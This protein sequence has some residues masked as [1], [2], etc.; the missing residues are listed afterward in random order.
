MFNVQ[1][2]SALD[3]FLQVN[4]TLLTAGISTSLLFLTSPSLATPLGNGQYTFDRAPRFME[5]NVSSP[6][7]DVPDTLYQ[8][9]ITV[10][11]DAGAPLQAIRI[12]QPKNQNVVRFQ[13]NTARVFAENPAAEIPLARIGGDQPENS[14]LTVEFQYP[15][16]PGQTITINFNPEHNPASGGVYLLGV[17][18]YPIGDNSP[19]L[20]LGYRPI[21]IQSPSGR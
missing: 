3:Q 7:A 15:V 17:T 18:A 1:L 4:I 9:T 10:P 5:V 14:E 6:Q 20:F 16:Q 2:R 8:L 11:Q 13:P 19:G 12:T 21:T